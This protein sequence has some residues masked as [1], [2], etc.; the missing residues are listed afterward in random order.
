MAFNRIAD[1]FRNAAKKIATPIF[2][3]VLV[4]V[5]NDVAN[6]ARANA[7]WSSRIEASITV[8]PV[9][10]G[11]GYASIDVYAD[12]DI[13][14]MAVAYEYGSGERGPEG[15]TYPIRAVNAPALTFFWLPG[16]KKIEPYAEL[17][18][19][20]RVDHPGV[21]ANS[22]LQPALDDHM[23]SFKAKAAGVAA[24]VIMEVAGTVISYA[25]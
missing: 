14:P 15:K 8:S 3:E 9:D 23:E 22:F 7:S 10:Y 4:S 19:F 2:T 12:P 13:A 16:G 18:S 21:E 25:S 6:D 11:Q 17:V 5:A 1:I 24:E 20:Q